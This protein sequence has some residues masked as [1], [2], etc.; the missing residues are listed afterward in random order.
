T[1]VCSR[2]LRALDDR[3]VFGAPREVVLVSAMHDESEESF[4]SAISELNSERA[5]A[6]VSAEREAG[7][8]IVPR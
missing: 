4:M 2:A 8:A 1:E 5:T 7:F 6:R 3:G